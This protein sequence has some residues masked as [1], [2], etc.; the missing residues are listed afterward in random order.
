MRV[1]Y[2]A[3]KN[4]MGKSNTANSVTS[5]VPSDFNQKDLD[6]AQADGLISDEDQVTFPSTECIP[7]PLSGFRVIFLLFSCVVFLFLPTSSIVGFF[8]CTVCSFTSSHQTQFFTLLILL[9]FASRFWGSNPIFFY[10]NSSFDS[11]PVS[12]YQRSLSWAGLLFLSMLNPS[13]WSF[14]WLPQYK[15]GGRNGFISKIERSLPLTS[16]A[17]PLLTPQKK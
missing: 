16:T 6:K 2:L 8:S 7:K 17:L 9:P 4:K 1:K 15:V 11:A 10:K 3:Q 14:P 12:L 13:I 5:W